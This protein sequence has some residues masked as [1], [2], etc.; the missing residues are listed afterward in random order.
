MKTNTPNKLLLRSLGLALRATRKAHPIGLQSLSDASGV[1]MSCISVIE[2]GESNP[3]I[4]TI[5]RLASALGTTPANILRQA[6]H[7][8]PEAATTKTPL[9]TQPFSK[10]QHGTAVPQTT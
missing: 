8:R 1:A 6:E 3:T 9:F 5:D 2:R 10:Q 4:D 7:Y